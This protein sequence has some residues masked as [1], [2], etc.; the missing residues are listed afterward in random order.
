MK[1]NKSPGSDGLTTEF[2]KIFW[3]TL[4]PFYISSIN[5]SYN[6]GSLTALQKQGIITL[7]PKKDKDLISLTNW[8]PISLLNID[9][10]IATKAIANRMKKVLNSLIHSSQTGFLKGRYIGENIRTIFE[11]IENFNDDNLPGIIFFADFEKAFDSIDHNF[12][13]KCLNYFNFGKSFIDWVKL[14][15][16]DAQSCVINNGYTSDFFKIERGVRQGCPLSPY[17]FILVIE[18]LYNAVRKNEHITGISLNGHEIKNTAFADDATFILDGSKT[19]FVKLLDIINKF[20]GMSGLKLNSKKSIMFRTG[21]LKHSTDTYGTNDKFIWTN[22]TASTLGIVFANN[23]LKYQ[24]LNIEPKIKEFCNCLKRWKRHKLSL[25]GKITVIKT[26]ALPKII[27]PLTVLETPNLEYINLIKKSM[28][29]FLWDGKPDK[30]NRKTIVQDY[31]NGGLKMIEIDSFI[32]S[33]K[34]GWVK[35]LS[36]EHNSGDWKTIYLKELQNLGGLFFF[37][38]NINSNDAKKIHVK[39]KFLKEIITS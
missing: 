10:K 36:N 25:L 4:K 17:L 33:I 39:S 24:E 21:S 2:Y 1:N 30:I 3:S 31:K 13:F 20:T 22:D 35:R 6:N 14:F 28:F 32:K 8:R 26:F 19:S 12:I 34:A 5:F 23:R 9:Y 38:C 11:V 27:Y 37:K 15:Y 18:I 7:L 29:D 16:I